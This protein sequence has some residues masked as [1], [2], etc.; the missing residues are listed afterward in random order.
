VSIVLDAAVRC[1]RA[2]RSTA[3]H[4]TVF[5]SVRLRIEVLETRDIRLHRVHVTKP[6]MNV[7]HTK[8]KGARFT[9]SADALAGMW[10][11][12]PTRSFVPPTVKM[13]DTASIVSLLLLRWP[14]PQRE[15]ARLLHV[16]AC[17]DPERKEQVTLARPVVLVVQGRQVS[18]DGG[19]R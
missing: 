4:M 19:G 1:V 8:V 11:V 9:P 16:S 18:E 6:T 3:G 12:E 15:C 2:R 10:H 13:A 17:N 14:Q 7:S 5:V